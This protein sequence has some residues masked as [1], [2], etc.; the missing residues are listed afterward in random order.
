MSIWT[1]G[2]GVIAR[3]GGA[4]EGESIGEELFEGVFVRGEGGVVAPFVN[5]SSRWVTFSVPIYRG[6]KGS[7]MISMRQMEMKCI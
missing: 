6:M 5:V 7:T 2:R 3:F 4:A 1:S